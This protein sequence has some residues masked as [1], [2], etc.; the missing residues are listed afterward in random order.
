MDDR[1]KIELDVPR[2]PSDLLM[3][4][5]GASKRRAQH[6]GIALAVVFGILLTLTGVLFLLENEVMTNIQYQQSP[7]SVN[8]AMIVDLAFWD[9][10]D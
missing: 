5:R 3:L 9:T 8:C 6:T 10:N 1:H 7:P 2:Q 4:N